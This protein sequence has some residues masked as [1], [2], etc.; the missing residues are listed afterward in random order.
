MDGL[1]KLSL[2]AALSRYIFCRGHYLYTKPAVLKQLQQA[3]DDLNELSIDSGILEIPEKD[4]APFHL[5]KD[6]MMLDILCCAM[7]EIRCK[8][9]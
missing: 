5:L 4:F 7:L 2:L 3:T 8:I 1:L 9:R 6:R